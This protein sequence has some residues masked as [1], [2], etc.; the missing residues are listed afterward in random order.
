MSVLIKPGVLVV[1]ADCTDTT[2]KILH[3]YKT[4]I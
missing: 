1:H 4:S 2:T 3:K